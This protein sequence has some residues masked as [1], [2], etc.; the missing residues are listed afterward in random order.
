V[1][2]VAAVYD[3]PIV[4]VSMFS[5]ADKNLQVA[6]RMEKDTNKLNED[7]REN[8]HY[9]DGRKYIPELGEGGAKSQ[10]GVFDARE[11]GLLHRCH[12]KLGGHPDLMAWDVIEHLYQL[13][14]AAGTKWTS[15]STGKALEEASMTEERISFNIATESESSPQEAEETASSEPILNTISGENEEAPL[16]PLHICRV[17]EIALDP[18]DPLYLLYHCQGPNYDAFGE[19][20]L[21][22]AN[23]TAIHSPTWGRRPFPL[24][25]NK[26]ILFFGNSHTRQTANAFLCQYKDQLKSLTPRVSGK[27]GYTAE[28]MNGA[29]VEALINSYAVFGREW[30]SLM[31]GELG[32]SL[33]SYDALVLG[34]FNRLLDSHNTT[35]YTEMEALSKERDDID[36]FN[37]KPPT[38]ADV[39]AVYDGPIVAVSMFSNAKMPRKAANGMLKNAKML[40]RKGRKN[41]Y[42]IDGRKY[43]SEVGEG[44]S[45]NQYKIRDSV[46]AGE[47][48]RCHGALGGHP[49][50]MAWDVIE[51]LYRLL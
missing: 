41:V 42:Y 8:V 49:D 45:Q 23:N 51:Q 50:L 35:F 22:F 15:K 3:G 31:E 34:K 7:G 2:E 21:K 9:I 25:A 38:L 10:L 4:A 14:P 1:A 27:V 30:K 12:G 44:G 32:R 16:P 47:T 46:D 43:T 26:S 36:F 40:H 33:A 13:V 39:A 18:E 37:V 11:D 20:L 28:F 29:K 24:P 19:S 48:H 5:S 17:P 6:K